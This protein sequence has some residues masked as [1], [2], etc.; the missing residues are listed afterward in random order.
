MLPVRRWCTLWIVL[1]T[2]L[3]TRGQV[4]GSASDII[5]S[6]KEEA[7]KPE[8][9]V[10]LYTIKKIYVDGNSHTRLPVVLRELSFHEGDRLPLNQIV[11]RFAE[12][13]KQLLNSELFHEVIISLKS[14]HDH[15]VYVQV[16]VKERWYI[17]PF[18]FF[19]IADRNLAEWRRHGMSLDRVNYGIDLSHKNFTGRNDQFHIYLMSGFTRQIE[20]SYR[21]L[22]LDSAMR[23]TAGFSVA[24]GKTREIN[25]ETLNSK[26]VAYTNQDNYVQNFFRTNLEVVYRPALK[27]RHT[28]GLGYNY[29]NVD[30]TVYKL[31]PNF[32]NYRV[33]LKYPE[34]YYRLSYTDVDYYPYPKAGFLGEF[35]V[36]RKGFNKDVNLT[37]VTVKASQY[38]PL[39]LNYFLNIRAIGHVKL[40]F[41]QPYVLRSFL[42]N[43]GYI[44]GFEESVIDGVAGG[45]VKAA[46]VRQLFNKAYSIPSKKIDRLNHIPV[47][48]YGK[49]FGDA[50]YVYDN[51]PAIGSVNNRLLLSAGLG[52]DI[53]VFYDWIVKIEWSVNA[54]GQKGLYLHRRDYY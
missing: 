38:W 40:P 35:Y 45:Y 17:Y 12:S 16:S 24:Y 36:D 18:P 22:F 19:R 37:Q 53:V 14:F 33:A 23:W 41:D 48:I 30:D 7:S 8:D 31:N 51:E 46:L 50:G 11:D 47:R 28:F 5:Y 2:A 27:T 42:P 43:E 3:S 49:I 21:G 34:A 32:S 1:F 15:D 39:D 44:Q 29:L 10:T 25:Y 52:L 4:I 54:L 26:L 6:T 9:S 13:K 20:L